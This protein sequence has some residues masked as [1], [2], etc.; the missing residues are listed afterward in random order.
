MSGSSDPPPKSAAEYVAELAEDHEA[1]VLR[2]Q[3]DELLVSVLRRRS[4][5][6][7]NRYALLI[8]A[9]LPVL[10]VREQTPALLPAFC[11]DRHINSDGSFCMGWQ[12]ADPLNVVDQA[13]AGEWWARLLKFLSL[14]EIANQLRRWPSNH[15]WAHGDAAAH[16]DRAERCAR[17]LGPA[18]ETALAA[19]RLQVIRQRRRSG[20][21]QL[22]DGK[23]RLYSVWITCR[24]VATGRQACLCGSGQ[25]L[26][27]CEDHADR[28][29][30][31]VFAIEARDRAE[32]EFWK[33][34]A[35][36]PCCSSLAVC[37]LN[38]A[39]TPSNTDAAATSQRAA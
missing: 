24:R 5:G 3:G 38:Q 37:P 31:L 36:R 33:R 6:R 29:A 22:M 12:A 25:P 26:R 30:E 35:G 19:K 32:R 10:Q 18:F 23:R 13:S 9:G 8:D 27:S 34:A 16:Q 2:R 4:D 1:H 21:A 28:A 20:F 11:P 17:A 14:Q 15:E 7:V 39:L